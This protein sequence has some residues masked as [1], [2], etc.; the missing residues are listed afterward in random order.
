MLMTRYSVERKFKPKI[1]VEGIN[2]CRECGKEFR[3][4]HTYNRAVFC[5]IECR[6]MRTLKNNRKNG[7]KWRSKYY[8]P[9]KE[10][11]CSICS[12]VY[13][14][15]GTR[16]DSVYCGLICMREGQRFTRYGISIEEYRKLLVRQKGLCAACLLPINH[17]KPYIDHNHLTGKVRGLLH[18]NCNST[19]GFVKDNPEALENM[20][21]YLR[22]T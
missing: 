10:R 14:P 5:S 15:G 16:S 12:K 20:A 1:P 22:S 6:K 9:P 21:T 19:L 4:L 7:A 3:A 13:T 2:T 18:A 17:K 8:H 11:P